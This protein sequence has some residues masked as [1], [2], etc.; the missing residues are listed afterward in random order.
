MTNT[1]MSTAMR[2]AADAFASLK[3]LESDPAGYT[4]QMGAEGYANALAQARAATAAAD[5][6]SAASR[7]DAA[8]APRVKK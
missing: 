4:R 6:A 3:R 2:R 7:W 8:A 1:L 5:Q